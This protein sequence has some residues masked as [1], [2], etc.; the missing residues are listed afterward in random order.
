M[1]K[2]TLEYKRAFYLLET[3]GVLSA[4]NNPDLLDLFCLHSIFHEYIEEDLSQL[5][6]ILLSRRKRKSTRDPLFPEG[7]H[8]PIELL[9]R[10]QHHGKRVT[11]DFQNE[12]QEIAD[13]Y[14]WS[15]PP[16]EF[17]AIPDPLS[18]QHLR[19]CRDLLMEWH[20]PVSERPISRDLPQLCTMYRAMRLYTT[21]LLQM[22]VA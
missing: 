12:L 7:T 21:V 3:E 13:S 9:R 4:G 16:R 14:R 6:R 8:R 18:Q 10:H 20:F 1:N 22:Q 11:P 5:Y 2:V 17:D 15:A 19:H